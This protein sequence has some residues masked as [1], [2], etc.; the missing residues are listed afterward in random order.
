MGGGV[1]GT[2]KYQG[3]PGGGSGARGGIL[4]LQAGSPGS[5][6][7]SDTDLRSIFAFL[8][9]LGYKCQGAEEGCA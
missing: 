4:W 1:W 9:A 8:G 3:S 7:A 6:L 5:G 2:L